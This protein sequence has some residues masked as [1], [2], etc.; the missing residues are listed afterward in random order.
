MFRPQLVPKSRPMCVRLA[1]FLVTALLLPGSARTACTL[2]GAGTAGAPYLVGTYAELKLVGT[3]CDLGATYRMTADIDASASK[4]ENN[5][6]GFVP[7]GG[8]TAFS[9]E[10]SGGGFA[11][12]NLFIKSSSES[13]VGLF[14]TIATSG[15]VDSLGLI[16]VEIEGDSDRVG[17]LAGFNQGQLV[18][19][20][21][22]GLVAGNAY[23]GGLAGLNS[24]TIRSVFTSTSTTGVSVVGGIVGKNFGNVTY[25]SSEMGISISANLVNSYSVGV[26]NGV[27]S[28]GGLVGL[29][30]GQI[31]MTYAAGGVSGISSIGGIA[32]ENSSTC[33]AFLDFFVCGGVGEDAEFS[34]WNTSASGLDSGI[35]FGGGPITEGSFSGTNT[36]ATKSLCGL[37]SSQMMDSAS[38]VGFS[39]APDSAWTIVQGQTFPLLR[40]MPG[41]TAPQI[42]AQ[43]AALAASTAISLRTVQLGAAS[44]H[45]VGH[46]VDLELSNSSDVRV[47]DV[48]G[49]QVMPETEFTAGIHALHLPESGAILLVRVRTGLSTTTLPLLPIR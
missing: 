37:V 38:F 33:F 46:S 6:S 16:G 26:T 3:S 22:T 15:V 2:S 39:F 28:T 19:D 1:V 36:G 17:G 4:T 20:F 42:A 27:S 5:G 30:Q 8:T 25:N 23:V 34:Y 12:H 7:I 10:F 31:A 18:F 21:V 14:G 29:N 35:G 32:G 45:R 47:I 11:I 40:G 9:G 43:T 41:G 24:G 44:L 48:F 49:H 13:G